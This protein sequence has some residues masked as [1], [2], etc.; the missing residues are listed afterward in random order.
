MATEHYDT[1][2]ALCNFR[3][4]GFAPDAFLVSRW[5]GREAVSR[6]YRF[7]I[8]VACAERDI[9]LPNLLGARATLEVY[10][11]DGRA[12]PWHG[13]ITQAAHTGL[14][15]DYA[16]YQ[17]VLEPQLALLAQF[18]ASRVYV[19]SDQPD[20]PWPDLA[21]LI[22]RTLRLCQ[23]TDEAPP[24]A[25]D[26]PG[27][28]AQS[29]FAIRVSDDDIALTQESFIC[30]FEETSLDFL[31]RRL[32]QEG[33]YYWFEQQA[34][35]EVVVFGNTLQQQP[36]T[37]TPL[38]WRPAGD[39]DPE[40]A[41]A[42]VVRF[43][44]RMQTQPGRVTLR[45]FS[46]SKA[47]LDLTIKRPVSYD[48][49]PNPQAYLG[50]HAVYAEHYAR[51]DEGA[52]LATLRA[53]EL[54]CRRL[55]VMATAQAP[56]V[57]AGYPVQLSDHFREDA[58]AAF[59]VIEAEHGGSQPL[60]GRPPAGEASGSTYT[61]F[62]AL[63]ADVQFRPERLTPKPR[64]IGYVSAIVDAEGDGKYAEMNDN[65]CYRVRFPFSAARRPDG[66]N[67]AWVRMATPYAGDN[68]GMQLP[69]LKG[70]EVLISFISGDPDRPVIAGAVPNSRNPSV[71][72]GRN[73]TVS[74][75]RTA[76]QNVLAFEDHEG[77]QSARLQSPTASSMILLG[78]SQADPDKPGV[79]IASAHHVDMTSGTFVQE[80]PG[81][82]RRVIGMEDGGSI[83]PDYF[84]PE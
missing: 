40:R 50:D 12:L 19:D 31:S 34:D 64:V 42:P 36:R 24:N 72:S 17:L 14:D 81:V 6:P 39:L 48:T 58:N 49:A 55:Q 8:E 32:E 33:V 9:P 57:R 54:A 37:I 35:H 56:A 76:G 63:P 5:E 38:V 82:F 70:T 84:K 27:A 73:P 16:L 21:Y 67:S 43:E 29:H 52:R 69:L 2:D 74:G 3:C 71:V 25:G 44:Q 77:R 68:E 83:F 61:H 46:A 51:Q 62:T 28:L 10:L 59:Y 45:D 15:D 26:T 75:L 22:R 60:P 18:R 23:L 79:R 65:G 80:V 1:R 20:Q 7:E 66:R 53:E 11:P 41:V 78:A 30:Q 13:V 4:T 47:T